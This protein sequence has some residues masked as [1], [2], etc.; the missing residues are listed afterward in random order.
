LLFPRLRIR[1]TISGKNKNIFT[2]PVLVEIIKVRSAS[3][4]S[5]CL[6]LAYVFPLIFTPL[7]CL[8]GGPELVAGASA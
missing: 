1:V 8:D 2:E 7:S 6:S 3:H 4:F 5:L